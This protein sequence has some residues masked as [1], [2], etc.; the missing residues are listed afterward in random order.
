M[1][2]TTSIA[3][4]PGGAGGNVTLETKEMAPPRAQGGP[5]PPPMRQG[6]NMA[7]K[8]ISGIKSAAGANMT[9]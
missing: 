2:D 1:T 5:P 6:P 8:I 9:Q 3:A 4:L 7:N